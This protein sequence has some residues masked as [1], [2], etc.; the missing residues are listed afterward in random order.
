[1]SEQE[2]KMLSD[3]LLRKQAD[4]DTLKVSH[5]EIGGYLGAF[6]EITPEVCSFLDAELSKIYMDLSENAKSALEEGEE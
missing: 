4:Y 5:R 1:M 2:V 3:C 6:I